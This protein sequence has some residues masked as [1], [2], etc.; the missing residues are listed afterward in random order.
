MQ[1]KV[2]CNT[3]VAGWGLGMRRDSRGKNKKKGGKKKILLRPKRNG[4]K[5]KTSTNSGV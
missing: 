3:Q 2:E 5:K 1:K 4:M